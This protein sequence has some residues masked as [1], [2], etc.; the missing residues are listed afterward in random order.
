VNV[1]PDFNQLSHKCRKMASDSTTKVYY[2]LDDSTPYMSLIPVAPDK[3]TL[4]DFKKV[5]NRREYEYYCM[6]FDSG[7][8]K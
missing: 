1:K 6:V 4:G 2:Y 8:G 7:I 5:F 3:I